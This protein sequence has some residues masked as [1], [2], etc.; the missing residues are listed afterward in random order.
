MVK[1]EDPAPD[2][3]REDPQVFVGTPAAVQVDKA[4]W[5]ARLRRLSARSSPTT[6]SSCAA[7]SRSPSRRTAATW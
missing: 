7:T 2:F 3:S 5:K 6:R 4:A 1:E